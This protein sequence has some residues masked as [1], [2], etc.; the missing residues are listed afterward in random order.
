MANRNLCSRTPFMFGLGPKNWYSAWRACT[1]DNTHSKSIAIKKDG[2][3]VKG[4]FIGSTLCNIA[5]SSFTNG[6][7]YNWFNDK[8]TCSGNLNAV[9]YR[10]MWLHK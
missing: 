8:C 6:C 7:K 10:T 4:S 1:N 2:S 5:S 3:N 9:G